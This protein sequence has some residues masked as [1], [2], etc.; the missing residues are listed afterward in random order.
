MLPSYNVF[1][2]TFSWSVVEPLQTPALIPEQ[3]PRYDLSPTPDS[4]RKLNFAPLLSNEWVMVPY[5]SFWFTSTRHCLTSLIFGLQDCETGIKEFFNSKL[6]IIGYVGIGIAGVMVSQ[7]LGRV[8]N[9]LLCVWEWS[10]LKICFPPNRSLGWSS[11]WCSVVRF[12]TAGRS[13]KLDPWPLPLIPPVPSPE[14]LYSHQIKCQPLSIIHP[15]TQEIHHVPKVPF[16]YGAQSSFPGLIFHYFLRVFR[17]LFCCH[18]Q[19]CI[20]YL[21]L[22]SDKT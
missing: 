5:K 1:L 11:V 19:S 21:S 15:G 18:K 14:R 6:Y 12:A 20:L 22:H 3:I 4:R 7:N 16:H 2:P 8:E 10:S 13:S 9:T 17:H